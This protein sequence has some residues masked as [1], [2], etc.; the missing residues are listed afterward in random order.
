M[1]KQFEKLALMRIEENK[2]YYYSI[3]P[4]QRSINLWLNP[5]YSH[6]WPVEL[7]SK[8]DE[9]KIDYNNKSFI[10]KFH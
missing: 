10:Q 2:L 4:L 5:Y 8:L 9:E 1:D 3:L 6:G 7:S